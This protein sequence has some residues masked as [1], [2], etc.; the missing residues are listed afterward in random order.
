MQQTIA[1]ITTNVKAASVVAISTTSTGIGAWFSWIPADIAKLGGL[2]GGILSI[3][4]II[5][6]LRKS[7]IQAEKA[8]LEMRIMIQRESDRRQEVADRR[9]KHRP[10]NRADDL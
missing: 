9:S 1:D 10:L 8:R 2:L 7:K 6:H 4:L 3:V 5:T